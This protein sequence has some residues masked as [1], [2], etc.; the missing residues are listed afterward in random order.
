M[1][2]PTLFLAIFLAL[3]ISTPGLAESRLTTVESPYT[4]SETVGRIEAVLKQGGIGLAARIDHAAAARAAGL[5]LP[6]TQVLLFGNPKVG[7]PL[8]SA[9]P[10]IAI[11]LPMRLLVWQTSD[12]TVLIGYVPPSGLLQRYELAERNDAAQAMA[13]AL[14]GIAEAAA[15]GN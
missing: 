11:E 8:I 14:A 6:D 7:T 3:E 2:M 5:E 12:G 10:E 9:S 1:R 13:G 4:V 15:A